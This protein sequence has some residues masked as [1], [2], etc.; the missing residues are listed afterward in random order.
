MGLVLYTI[1]VIIGGDDV[2][3][4]DIGEDKTPQRIRDLMVEKKLTYSDLSTLTG[5]SK[6]TLQRYATGTTAHIPAYRLR[7]IAEALGVTIGYLEGAEPRNA[8]DIMRAIKS[9]DNRELE[10]ALGVPR[11]TILAHSDLGMTKEEFRE[12]VMA[13]VAEAKKNIGG[14][15]ISEDDLKFALFGCEDVSDEA[16]EDVKR[17]AEWIKEKHKLDKEKEQH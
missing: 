8:I 17:Y 4:F 10:R 7:Q 12:F 16:F 15:N 14:K 2:Y 9:G 13:D 6:S 1:A 11:G 3:P 5:I